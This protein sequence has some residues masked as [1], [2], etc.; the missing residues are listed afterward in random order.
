MKY[1]STSQ[2]MNHFWFRLPWWSLPFLSLTCRTKALN[3]EV[4]TCTNNESEP[5][6]SYPVRSAPAPPPH[7]YQISTSKSVF[8]LLKRSCKANWTTSLTT[9][10]NWAVSPTASF[11][12]L[13]AREAAQMPTYLRQESEGE[14]RSE[15]S[16]LILFLDPDKDLKTWEGEPAGVVWNMQL[17]GNYGKVSRDGCVE[18]SSS[19]P[20]QK[21]CHIPSLGNTLSLKKGPLSCECGEEANDRHEGGDGSLLDLHWSKDVFAF[22]PHSCTLVLHVCLYPPYQLQQRS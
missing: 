3:I 12:N 20:V 1:L 13:L 9:V 14:G 4:P 18:T 8:S 11:H 17:K 19:R 2:A 16:L 6:K 15:L 10:F 7:W 21:P 22:I 5:R